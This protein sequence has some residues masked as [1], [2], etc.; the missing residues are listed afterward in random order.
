MLEPVTCLGIPVRGAISD[1]QTSLRDAIAQLWPEVPHPIC[2]FHSLQDAA[3]PSFEV[4]R[5]MRAKMRKTLSEK[6]R[7]FRPQIERQLNK[8]K[9]K[10]TE[11][12]QSEQQQLAVLSE[13]ALAAQTSFHLD[14]KLPFTSPGL[15]GYEALDAL[16]ES[17][18]RLEKGGPSLRE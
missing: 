7:P 12:S 15:E 17:L 2:H 5:G 13:Y 16:D 4:D 8:L 11:Q 3:R 9:A 1:A 6:W 18:Q 14:G 10:E